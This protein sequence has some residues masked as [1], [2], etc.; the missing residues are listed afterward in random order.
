MPKMAPVAAASGQRG[1]TASQLRAASAVVVRKR[2]GGSERIQ[3]AL[4]MVCG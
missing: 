2:A 4:V 1:R 3:L